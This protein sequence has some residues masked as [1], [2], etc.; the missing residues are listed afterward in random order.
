MRSNRYPSLRFQ[1]A[2]EEHRM[3]YQRQAT[4]IMSAVALIVNNVPPKDSEKVTD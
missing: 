1:K 4:E 3:T 2:P